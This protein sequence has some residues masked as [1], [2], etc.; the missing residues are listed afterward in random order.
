[1][2]SAHALVATTL[3]GATALA[4]ALSFAARPETVAVE[5]VAGERYLGVNQLARLLGA[6]K[7]WRADVRQLT[8]RAGAHAI[9]LTEDNPF[10][11]VD[12]ATEWLA[13][14]VISRAGELHVPVALL[15][16]LPSDSTLARLYFDERVDRVV[17]LPSGGV[18][19]S[20][21][22]TVSEAG[23]R[24]VF[25]ADRP[26]DALVVSRSRAHFQI[27]TSGF[28]SGGLPDSLP[29]GGLVR[30]MIERESAVGSAFEFEVDPLAAGYRL[31][32]D[33]RM[34]RITLELDRTA[35]P[36]LLAFAPEGAAGPR[37]LR[38]IVI[39]PGHGG[40]DAGVVVGD[41]SEKDLTLALA[42]RLRSEI[43][44]RLRAK[45]VL[46]RDDDRALS[47]EERAEAANRARAD[48]VLSLHFDGFAGPATR[49]ASVLVP[50]ATYAAAEGGA[51]PP[52]AVVPWRDVGTRHAV[53]SRALAEAIMA[54]LELHD[55]GP[56]HLRELLPH[57]LLGVNAPGLVLEC[58]TLTSRSDRERLAGGGVAALAVAIA[59]GVAAYQRNE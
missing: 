46:T 22:L 55:R 13:T 9:T 4:A 41:L 11:V 16:R 39:D 35:A 34:R 43:Q 51:R 49:G 36:G 53:Q 28:F 3:L 17:V 54:A 33:R 2:R 29:P 52:I 10:V 27:R 26:E 40:A 1:M 7:Y 31:V 45:V 15:E 23:T 8:L 44:R 56:T 37:M 48:L 20:P 30:R 21:R 6:T 57:G 19:G 42:R 12:A 5:I 58:A 14:P 47:I 59:D 50:P 38:T 24:I 18:V 25:P 32:T